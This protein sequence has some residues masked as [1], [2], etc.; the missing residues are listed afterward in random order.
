MSV[1]RIPLSESEFQA[2][3]VQLALLRQYL[4]FH[5]NDSRRNQAGFPDL[6][7]TRPG[8]LVFAELKTEIGRVSNEQHRWLDLLRSVSQV[9][10]DAL[11]VAVWRPS[12]LRSGAIARALT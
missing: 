2:A 12:D 4:V 9:A 5:D 7:M 6:V 10:G 1:E 3:V 8:R 11:H